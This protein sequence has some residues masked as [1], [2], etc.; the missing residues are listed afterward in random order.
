MYYVTLLHELDQATLVH[1]PKAK[2]F[3]SSEEEV[4]EQESPA[5]AE[6][7]ESYSP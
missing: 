6:F 7:E 3:F 5:Q 4:K 2:V 1:V